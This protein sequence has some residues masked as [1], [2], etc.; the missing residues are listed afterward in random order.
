MQSITNFLSTVSTFVSNSFSSISKGSTI[1]ELFS[2]TVRN[3]LM[4]GAGIT[5]TTASVMLCALKCKKTPTNESQLWSCEK[6]F[7]VIQAGQG[8]K[9]E[10]KNEKSCIIRYF[11][12]EKNMEACV[13]PVLEGVKHFC[14]IPKE[15]L[16]GKSVI[17]FNIIKN[18][19]K[20]IFGKNA[21]FRINVK[22]LN[23]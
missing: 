11:N 21:Y 15:E 8:L 18:K 23:F 6:P 19:T 20:W 3:P 2:R 5:A 17:R 12:D 10:V 13:E 14:V 16:Q 9:I 1:V 4:I 7:G 22:K